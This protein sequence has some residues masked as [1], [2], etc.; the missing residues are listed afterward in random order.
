[1]P[2]ILLGPGGTT[3]TVGIYRSVSKYV[4]DF[5]AVFA[6]MVLATIPILVLFL[7]FQ[8]YFVKGLMSGATKG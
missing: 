8:R 4:S 5:G 7:F 2:L 3:V 6:F 1:M